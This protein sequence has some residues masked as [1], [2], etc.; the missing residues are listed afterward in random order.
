M[1]SK[2]TAIEIT[3]ITPSQLIQYRDSAFDALVAMLKN[4]DGTTRMYALGRDGPTTAD[5][6]IVG[7]L[8]APLN[9]FK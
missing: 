4:E 1:K 6:C 5:S 9:T 3:T 8:A 2:L 7:I